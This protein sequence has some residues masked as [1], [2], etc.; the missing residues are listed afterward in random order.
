MGAVHGEAGR[1]GSPSHLATTALDAYGVRGEGTLQI[2]TREGTSSETLVWCPDSPIESGDQDFPNRNYPPNESR[3]GE[4]SPATFPELPVIPTRIVHDVRGPYLGRLAGPIQFVWKLLEF[5]RLEAHDAVGLLG[6]DPEDAD[7]VS[8]VLYGREHLRGR[9]VRDRISHLF[10]IRKTLRS[11]C[12]APRCWCARSIRT[13][14]SKT[15]G[16]ANRTLCWTTDP[17]CHCCSVA[18]WKICC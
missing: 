13:W 18:P 2:G 17:P 16:C 8:A 9:D 7:H 12:T 3:G 1:T 6:F 4:Q 14:K 10:W 11:L 15:S 5:W